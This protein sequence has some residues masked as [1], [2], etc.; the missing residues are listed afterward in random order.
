MTGGIVLGGVQRLE[1]IH[2]I[3]IASLLPNG[4]QESAQLIVICATAQQSLDVLSLL[5][6]KTSHQFPVGSETKSGATATERFRDRRDNTNIACAIDELVIHGGRAPLVAPDLPQWILRVDLFDNVFFRH[7]LRRCPM[8]GVAHVHGFDEAHTKTVLAGKFH[9]RNNI[10]LVDAAFD[11]GVE[12]DRRESRF[13]SSKDSFENFVE[14][15][16]FSHAS[17]FLGI[18][19]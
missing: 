10:V 16:A 18:Q 2:R 13:L 15:T 9:Q 3:S 12:L 4:T 17:K 8:V 11:Y 6:K 5:G 1:A 7:Q 19:C 14:I